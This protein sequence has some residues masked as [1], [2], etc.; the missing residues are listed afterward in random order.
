[1]EQIP[2]SEYV[3]GAREKQAHLAQRNRKLGNL[4]RKYDVT[5]DGFFVRSPTANPAAAPTGRT[6]LS[7]FRSGLWAESHPRRHEL[8]RAPISPLSLSQ[9]R[10]L[11]LT[12][13]L[14]L[15]LTPTLTL[16]Q[17]DPCGAGRDRRLLE[18]LVSGAYPTSY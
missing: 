4:S 16:T 6:R 11:L 5:N 9:R 10:I 12:L 14:A 3:E 7:S 15:T 17:G 2:F 1:M 18:P 8:R 13:T